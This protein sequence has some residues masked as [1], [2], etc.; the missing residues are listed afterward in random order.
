MKIYKIYILFLIT[1][2]FVSCS[3][4]KKKTCDY[5]VSDIDFLANYDSNELDLDYENA[6]SGFTIPSINQTESGYFNFN[7]KLTNNSNKEKE[8][9]YKIYYQNESYKIQECDSKNKAQQAQY[10]EE[11][12]Y[13]SWEDTNIGFKSLGKISPSEFIVLTDSFRIVGNPRNEEKYFFYGENDRWKR[14]P[15][16]GEYSF[17]LV[18]VDE[19]NF[20]QIPEYIKHINLLK[21]SANFVSPYYYFLYGEGKDI[22]NCFVKLEEKALKVTAKPNLGG[23]IYVNHYM[24]DETIEDLDK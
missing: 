8:Y 15:R 14:N 22:K 16:V 7:F 10:V 23:G 1:L 19:E 18:I 17:M 12:F 4:D 21:D 11:N 24:F 5:S 13:G 3:S 20:E 9:F 2:L 6:L